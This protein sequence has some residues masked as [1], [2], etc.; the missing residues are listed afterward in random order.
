MSDTRARTPNWGD[1]SDEGDAPPPPRTGY[2]WWRRV[3]VWPPAVI[4]AGIMLL[5]LIQLLPL[6]PRLTARDQTTDGALGA[7]PAVFLILLGGALFGVAML[8]RR[9]LDALD[10]RRAQ[11][12]HR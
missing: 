10:Q 8:I 5:G 6:L 9:A 2:V 12:P 11:P 4:G 3:L 1:E 7:G